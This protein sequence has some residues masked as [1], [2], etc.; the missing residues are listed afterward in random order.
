MGENRFVPM[1]G[2]RRLLSQ[3]VIDAATAVLERVPPGKSGVLIAG[4]DIRNGKPTA[5]VM[6]GQRINKNWSATFVYTGSKADGH[7]V[8]ATLT[9]SW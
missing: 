9:G 3:S 2:E 1:A 7:A 8:S 4:V 6:I 5:V